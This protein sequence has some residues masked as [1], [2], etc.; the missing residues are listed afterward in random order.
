M[1]GMTRWS[2]FNELTS[3]H[4]DLDSLFGRVF[5]DAA[6]SDAQP[7]TPVA[8]FTPAA[9]VRR[10]GDDWM[11]SMAIPGIDPAKVDINIAGRTLRISGERT[12]EGGDKTQP[13]LNELWYGRFERE[14]TLPEEIDADKVQASYR[15]GLLELT[16]P[17]KESV[18]PRRITIQPAHEARQLQAA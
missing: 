1:F 5:G 11:V 3:L 8:T 15:H 6:R 7:Q 17:L 2:P 16:L 12:F 14:F 10:T 4:R 13:V 18:K 9:D